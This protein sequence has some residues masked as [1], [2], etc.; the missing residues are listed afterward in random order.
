MDIECS[1][2]FPDETKIK[3]RKKKR[4]FI[5]KQLMMQTFINRR[6]KFEVKKSVILFNCICNWRIY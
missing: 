2:K 3:A 4:H 5:L 1:Q 6:K